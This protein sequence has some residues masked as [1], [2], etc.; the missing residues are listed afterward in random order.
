MMCDQRNYPVISGV[1]GAITCLALTLVCGM[2]TRSIGA[3]TDATSPEHAND[4][5]HLVIGE[6]TGKK[7][8]D[9][10]IDGKA[11]RLKKGVDIKDER[12]KPR[13]ETDLTVGAQ[14]RADLH[15]GA[16]EHIVVIQPR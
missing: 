16:V 12:G 3:P 9:L 5:G 14:V 7:E 11:Y 15:K 8:G 13:R 10:F 2:P 1:T 4:T 6:I